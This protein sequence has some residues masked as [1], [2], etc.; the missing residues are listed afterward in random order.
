M[1]A[2]SSYSQFVRRAR[3]DDLPSM[4][5]IINDWI[6]ET[7]WMPRIHSVA[8]VASNF[9]PE[10][11]DKRIIFVGEHAQ[12]IAGN[13]SIR[14]D[15]MIGGFYLA[16]AARGQ[17]LGSELMSAA[18]NHFPDFLEL[19]VLEPNI[20]AQKFYKSQGFVEVPEGRKSADETDDGIPEL[21]MRWEP[22]VA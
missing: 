15:H 16:S 5:M 11:L 6:D 14:H 13:L 20:G 9:A 18:K 4:A 17:G 22:V 7:E 3:I 21:L 2:A 1:S 12:K 10:L 19:G 8:E